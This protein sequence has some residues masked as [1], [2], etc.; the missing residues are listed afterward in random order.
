MPNPA[1]VCGDDDQFINSQNEVAEEL[2]RVRKEQQQRA[3]NELCYD[4]GA[5]ISKERRDAVPS[6]QR[7]VACEAAHEKRKST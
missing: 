2:E 4:C 1:Q 7:C 3:Y 6:T 5:K